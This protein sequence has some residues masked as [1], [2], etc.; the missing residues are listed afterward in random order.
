MPDQISS[1]KFAALYVAGE[2]LLPTTTVGPKSGPAGRFT[3]ITLQVSAAMSW[4]HL[5]HRQDGGSFHEW[6]MDW[7]RRRRA[8]QQKRAMASA[9]AIATMPAR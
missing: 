9:I 1:P 2:R 6:S 5:D 3:A 4:A 7:A 8:N